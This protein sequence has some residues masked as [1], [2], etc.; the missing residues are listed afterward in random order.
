VVF[1]EDI[2]PFAK[3][4]PNAGPLLKSEILLLA[5]SLIS[6]NPLHNSVN[7]MDEP[8][9]NFPNYIHEKCATVYG[10]KV[11]K[12]SNMDNQADLE[13]TDDNV[14]SVPVPPAWFRT[15]S[16]R[17]ESRAESSLDLAPVQS[18]VTPSPPLQASTGPSAPHA[19][20]SLP[21]P[22]PVRPAPV[23]S[24]SLAPGADPGWILSPDLLC[25]LL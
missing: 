11:A 2:F 19:S 12:S 15:M 6:S 23:G 13:C 17:A 21:P 24:Q 1:D 25:H 20:M 5:Q 10:V 14:D 4:H 3:L 22:S 7:I 9:A 16:G 8:G 18:A